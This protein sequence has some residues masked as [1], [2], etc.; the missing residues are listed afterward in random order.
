MLDHSPQ[1][2]FATLPFLQALEQPVIGLQSTSE[3]YVLRFA[4]ASAADLAGTEVLSDSSDPALRHVLKPDLA[5][6]LEKQALISEASK[7]STTLDHVTRDDHQTRRWR[8]VLTPIESDQDQPPIIVAVGTEVDTTGLARAQDEEIERLRVRNRELAAFAG[9]VAHDMRGPLATVKMATQLTLKGVQ[10]LGDGKM[11]TIQ[12]CER[13]ADKCLTAI[14]EVM[15]QVSDGNVT[16]RSAVEFDVRLVCRK[17]AEIVD[18]AGRLT[19]QAPA[20]RILTDKAV[21]QSVVRNLLDNASRYAKANIEISVVPCKV[22]KHICI[23]ISDD[24]PGLP[25]D[26]DLKSHVYQTC[27]VDRS[28]GGYGLSAVA[29]LLTNQ[30]GTIDCRN[31]DRGAIFTITMPGTILSDGS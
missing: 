22:D 25:P 8:L 3:G 6:V 17:I 14:D 13:V 10:D 2:A 9:L 19:I 23:E 7:S 12:M 1:N 15:S 26:F 27:S 11:N 31:T 4:N 29:Q 16:E 24:G 21:F 30:G 20:G 28:R 5:Q 18:P